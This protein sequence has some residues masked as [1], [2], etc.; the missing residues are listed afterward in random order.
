MRYNVETNKGPIEVHYVNESFQDIQFGD[1]V[2]PTRAFFFLVSQIVINPNNERTVSIYEGD[3]SV[4]M[5]YLKPS[6]P[7]KAIL[8]KYELNGE[9]L[10]A[11]LDNLLF[12]GSCK[13]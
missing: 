7:K 10:G 11:L 4:K 9:D 1:L 8:G 5:E 2:I 12:E 6:G 3:I 13:S